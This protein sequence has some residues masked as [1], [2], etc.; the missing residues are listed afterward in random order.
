MLKQTR[1]WPLHCCSRSNRFEYYCCSYEKILYHIFSGLFKFQNNPET[2][3][4]L[5]L[6]VSMIPVVIIG[7]LFKDEIEA[8]FNQN[9]LLVGLMLLVTALLLAFTFYAKPREKDV[10]FF[11]SF[12]IGIAQA[13][14]VIARNF[15]IRSYHCNG[16]TCPE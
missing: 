11:N 13:V 16:I 7:L 3:Y 6:L 14:A 2:H 12:V 8:L 5:K 4:L 10:S 9:L 15:Q 1:T